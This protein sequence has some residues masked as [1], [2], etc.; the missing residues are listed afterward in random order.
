MKR[1]TFEMFG[2]ATPSTKKSVLRHLYKELVSDNSA[3]T[4]L[5]QTKIEEGVAAMFELEEPSL[6]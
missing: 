1:K 4:N 2:L 3:S 5:A 6:V